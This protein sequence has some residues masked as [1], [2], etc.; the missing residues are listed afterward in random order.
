VDV[1]I[2]NFSGDQSAI[3]VINNMFVPSVPEMAGF[4][5]L[6]WNYHLFGRVSETYRQLSPQGWVVWGG[7]HVANQAARVFR[8]WPA[9][10]VIVN[11]EGELTFLDVVRAFLA[12][13][14][15]HELHDVPGISFKDPEGCV[16]TTENCPRIANLDSILS[17]ILTG[18]ISLQ[19]S[20]GNFLYQSALMETNRGCPY[21]CAFCYWG[22]AIGQRIRSFSLDRLSAEIERLARAKAEVIELCDANFGILKADE[23]FLEICIRARERYGYPRRIS[24]S[25]AKNKGPGFYRIVRR[26][27]EAGF[28]STFNLALQSLSDPVLQDMGR[29]NMA[30][31]AW[32]D[33]AAWLHQEG[34]DVYGELIWG[35]P[36][37]TSESF[38][39][40]YDRLSRYVNRIAV[41]PHLLL[42]N[43][44]YVE[45]RD[46]FGFVTWRGEDHD[47][48]LVLAHNTMSVE[49]NRR[50][51]RFLFWARVIAEHLVFRHIWEPLR[52][53]GNVTQSQ[54]LKCLDNWVDHTSELTLVRL[55]SCRDQVVTALETAS[56]YLEEALGILFTAPD[57][58]EL[59]EQ[60]WRAEILPLFPE[61][62]QPFIL[63]LFRYDCISRPLYLQPPGVRKVQFDS[64]LYYVRENVLFEFDIPMILSRMKRGEKCEI[65]PSAVEL[66]FY[67]RVGFCND[68]TLYHNAQNALFCGVTEIP[69]ME[70]ESHQ[71]KQEEIQPLL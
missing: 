63:D 35:C 14:S 57:I 53:F 15:K 39:E 50:M 42:P 13:K 2:F 51:H 55:R 27:K 5:I 36:G 43:T 33:L 26:M 1:R 34:L 9:V 31:N 70:S 8:T 44:A 28:H 6:G 4:S 11:G 49:E 67:Y 58:S 17:P 12:G 71:C 47:F 19:D 64:T 69:G 38:I 24:T 46:Q 7:T 30:L 48:E 25:W 66:T 54:V 37:E 62:L 60:W 56:K 40:G 3:S 16:V 68:M 59:L 32:E 65:L 18:A 20:S 29:K 45:K 10:D 21:T 41:Y 22:G 61:S 23:E 52:Q